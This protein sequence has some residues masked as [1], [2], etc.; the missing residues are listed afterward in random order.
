M[1]DRSVWGFGDHGRQCR[2]HRECGRPP[3]GDGVLRDGGGGR[4]RSGVGGGV[5]DC[6]RR[7][8]PGP[9]QHGH[10]QSRGAPDGSRQ[11]R[12][13]CQRIPPDHQ[14]GQCQP[15][16]RN[17][18]SIA[19]RQ[20]HHGENLL[21]PHLQCRRRVRLGTGRPK[22]GGRKS[23]RKAL[24]VGGSGLVRKRQPRSHP[25]FTQRGS[26]IRLAMAW[27]ERDRAGA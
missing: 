7:E 3:T 16:G 6:Q 1:G 4:G 18:H 21:R 19:L 23:P 20:C 24:G 8:S 10:G 22:T 9:E 25:T 12:H 27:R 5:P 15:A 26:D 17:R 11:H 2:E 14:R 13:S